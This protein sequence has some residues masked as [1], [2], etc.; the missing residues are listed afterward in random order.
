MDH[1]PPHV[2]GP[3][4]PSHPQHSPSRHLPSSMLVPTSD[5][6]YGNSMDQD[7]PPHRTL[8][9]HPPSFPSPKSN[10]HAE[11]NGAAAHQYQPPMSNGDS[12]GHI[13]SNVYT[14]APSNPEIPP[15][16]L[17]GGPSLLN[18]PQMAALAVCLSSSTAPCVLMFKNRL[19][20]Q[21]IRQVAFQ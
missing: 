2:S 3:H 10:G 13:M 7:I 14:P 9:Q 21:I 8:P 15:Q 6:R 11:Q 20:K 18:N 19:H 17:Q 16:A 5:S 1:I 4:P 12:N